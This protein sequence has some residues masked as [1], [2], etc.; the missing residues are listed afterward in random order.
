MLAQ[1]VWLVLNATVANAHAALQDKSC[2]KLATHSNVLIP[3]QMQHA[4]AMRM[5]PD[6]Y[7]ANYP[8]SRTVHAMAGNVKSRAGRDLIIAT[9]TFRMAVKPI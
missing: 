5:G 4:A 2:A 3:M 1:N 6:W 8:I 7:A 9:R